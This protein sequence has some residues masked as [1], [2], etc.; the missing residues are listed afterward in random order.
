MGCDVS[1]LTGIDMFELLKEEDRRA[2]ADVVDAIKL[3]SGETL[4][5][6]G[7]PG[8]SLFIVRSGLNRALYQRHCR[9]KDR[10]DC[11]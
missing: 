9:A 11:R 4:F 7:E 8:D 1:L 2:L 6:A 10:F 5:E 3:S